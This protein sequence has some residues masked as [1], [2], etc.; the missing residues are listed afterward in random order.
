MNNVVQGRCRESECLMTP[1]MTPWCWCWSVLI[2]LFGKKERNLFRLFLESRDFLPALPADRI[3]IETTHKIIK[4]IL[5]GHLHLSSRK[6]KIIDT[7]KEEQ[8]ALLTLFSRRRLSRT[9][10]LLSCG[11][12]KALASWWWWLLMYQQHIPSYFTGNSVSTYEG[13]Y[14]R[15]GSMLL[16]CFLPSSI[17]SSDKFSNNG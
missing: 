9:P 2:R 11:E 3:T 4:E 13:V 5:A 10:I 16:C 12:L 15:L 8:K 6:K 7:H 1:K 14:A 17:S